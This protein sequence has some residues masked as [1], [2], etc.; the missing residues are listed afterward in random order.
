MISLPSVFLLSL[1]AGIFWKAPFI[2][3]LYILSLSGLVG[4][5]TNLIAIRMLFQPEKKT[6]LGRQGLIPA[7][8]KELA[9]M[10]AGE[11]EKRLLNADIL[12][13]YVTDNNLMDRFFELAGKG[14][15]AILSEPEA[16]KIIRKQIALFLDRNRD[17]LSS[18][19]REKGQNIID[20]FLNEKLKPGDVWGM[21]RPYVKTM[22]EEGEIR[23][24]LAMRIFSVIAENSK[25]IRKII[26]EAIEDHLGKQEG[27]RGLFQKIGFSLFVS[28]ED[29]EKMVL[30]LVRSKELRIKIIDFLDG[31]IRELDAYLAENPQIHRKLAEFGKSLLSGIA[32]E[33]AIPFIEQKVEDYLKT[34]GAW[35]TIDGFIMKGTQEIDGLVKE[36]VRNDRVRDK[37]T[38]ILSE[39][40]RMIDIR[41]IVKEQINRQDTAELEKMVRAVSNEQLAGIEVFGGLLGVLA[42]T[43]LISPWFILVIPAALAGGLAVEKGWEY[44]ESG[45]NGAS[46]YRRRPA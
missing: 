31:K 44:F 17:N 41:G 3:W 8:R 6:I 26:V 10:M 14:L 28:D 27:F 11:I 13:R 30:S 32:G 15:S 39:T 23:D 24:A 16:R 35:K 12:E 45:R 42:G 36:L 25:E 33:K 5:G 37:L 9:S 1:T 22:I 21:I 20:S 46:E 4:F 40:A 7:K 2:N 34:P 19:I 18:F 38:E 29:I 43:V